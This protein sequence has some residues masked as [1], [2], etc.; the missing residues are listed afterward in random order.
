MTTPPA[1]WRDDPEDP[2]AQRYWDGQQWTP[3]RQRKPIAA[4]PQPPVTPTPPPH[5]S[6]PT[7]QPQAPS[8]TKRPSGRLKTW[9]IVSGLA[10]LV[11][12]AALVTGRVM[13]GTFLPGLL[14]IAAIAL[15]SAIIAIRSHRSRTR[16]AVFITAVALVTALAVPLSMRI[17]YPT[18]HYFFPTGAAEAGGVFGGSSAPHIP[19]GSSAPQIPPGISAPHIPPGILMVDDDKWTYG[20]IDPS[21]GNYSEVTKF[22]VS[23]PETSHTPDT[24]F[25]PNL[26]A[27]PDLTKLAVTTSGAVGWIDTSGHFTNVTPIANYSGPSVYSIGFDS[28]GNFYYGQEVDHSS[29]IIG[30]EKEDIYK[31]AAG[32][33]SDAQ[34]VQSGVT[35]QD[36]KAAWLDYDG[37]IHF[38][39]EPR[40]FDPSVPLSWVGPDAILVLYAGGINKAPVTARDEKGCLVLGKESTLPPKDDTY[41]EFED[42]VA[43][44]DGS[45]IAFRAYMSKPFIDQMGN[46]PPAQPIGSHGIFITDGSSQ[47]TQLNAPNLPSGFRF[48]KWE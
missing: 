35:L 44:R 29:P 7:Q 36:M 30:N 13:L 5:L 3:Q 14:L 23:N 6:P 17:V 47:P 28:A 45:K 24:V 22:N 37:S 2:N 34:K 1:G 4:S 31:V 39:C 18:Y 25:V 48:L 38:G 20:V 19:P 27:S 33:T 15:I 9:L 32:S 10:L 12:T 26:A 41:G 40:Q 16:K 8:A 46:V 42:A 21:S 11:V 43:K